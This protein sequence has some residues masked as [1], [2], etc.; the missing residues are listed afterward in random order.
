[1]IAIALNRISR[2][3]RIQHMICFWC[4]LERMLQMLNS[5]SQV[6]AIQIGN[7]NVVVV[8]RRPENGSP[9]FLEF[10][11]AS[12]NQ[13][14]CAL[15][16]L[17]LLGVLRNHIFKTTNRLFEFLSVHQLDGSFIRLNGAGKMF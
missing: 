8:L 14:L 6:P 7:T 10:L 5:R 12:V 11:L 4:E 9:L 16:N 13:N 3:K 1:M 2:R 15:L 17:R